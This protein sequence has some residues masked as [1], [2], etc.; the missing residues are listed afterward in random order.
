ME[1]REQ[2]LRTAAVLGA[3]ALEKLRASKV[4]V[5]GLGGV[6]GSLCEALARSGVGALD[7]FDGDVISPSNINRQVLA[8]RSTVGRSK[9]SV[10]AE[11]IKDINPDC[12]V[13]EFPVFYLPENADLYPLDGY[14]YI[15]DAID[16]VAAKVELAVR[17]ARLG[18]PLLSAMGAGNKLDPTQFRVADLSKTEGC[19]LARTMRR[20]LRSRGILHLPVVYSPEIPVSSPPDAPLSDVRQS[21]RPAPGSLAFVPPVV[22]LIMAGEII[23][24]IIGRG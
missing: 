21:G 23:R 10:M 13:R 18:V 20:E 14:D 1:I 3:S 16:T 22:G 17:A 11:R 6:G 2:D 7:L 9:V 15:A 5:F 12:A 19:P 4:A 24:N 8:L